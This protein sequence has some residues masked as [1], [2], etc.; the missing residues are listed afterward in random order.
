MDQYFKLKFDI[1]L[2]KWYRTCHQHRNWKYTL[3][4]D[5]IIQTTNKENN[6]FK[7]ST[8][9]KRQSK[10]YILQSTDAM[11]MH[12][13]TTPTI[14]NFINNNSIKC[15]SCNTANNRVSYFKPST[16]INYEYWQ[17]KNQTEPFSQITATYFS[18]IID[19]Q[20]VGECILQL[21][22]TIV[23]FF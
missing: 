18:K 13:I 12:N 6:I 8:S 21:E 20:V 5:T 10:T 2:G 23:C 3:Y 22:Q 11:V 7:L 17:I 16:D 14:P 4:Q 1:S 15:N 19:N 9:R